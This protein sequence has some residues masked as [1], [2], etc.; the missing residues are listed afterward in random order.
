MAF[1][2]IIDGNTVEKDDMTTADIE[3]AVADKPDVV[4]ST[5]DP[6]GTYP[7]NTIWIKYTP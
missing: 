6:S 3:A 7:E 2:K 5:Q 4:V 1:R